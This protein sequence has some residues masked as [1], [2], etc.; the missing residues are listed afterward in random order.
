M[1]ST[2][3]SRR[4]MMT[5][6]ILLG[7]GASGLGSAQAQTAAG[8][9]PYKP[10]PMPAQVPA[11][12]GLA[13]LADTRL[14]YWDTG[15]DGQPIVL[16]HP[17]SG[18][19]LIWGYQQPVFVKAGYRVIAYSRRGHNGSDPVPKENPGIASGDLDHL[20]DFLGV[21]KF[22]AVSSAAG[23][24]VTM[25]Y[26]LSHADRL[27]S[28]VYACGTGGVQDE[29][30]VKM[31]DDL[32][33]KGF[34]EMPF[35]FQEVGP[36]YR[37]ANPEG[38]QQW[39]DLHHKAVT[40]V[41]TG[42]K[43]ANKVTLKA[44]EFDEGADAGDRRRRRPVVAADGLADGRAA[45][46]EQRDADRAGGRP[47]GLLGAARDVQPR[48]ARFHRKARDVR[49]RVFCK[50][51]CWPR[52][53]A[54]TPAPRS[55]DINYGLLVP[56]VINTCVIQ[57]VYA[58]VR[59]TTSYRA[60]E[61]NLSV[62]W[63]GVISATFAILPIFVAVRVGRFIDRGNDARAAWI[64]SGL[65]VAACA[66]FLFWS[67]SVTGLLLFTA[68][69]GVSHVYM[70]ASQQMLCIRSA[71]PRGR[72]AA[73][74]NYL[75]AAAIGQGLGP[76]V[77]AWAG[78][79]ATVPPTDKLFTIGLIIACVSMVTAGLLRPG[80]QAGRRHETTPRRSASHAAAPARPHGD[81][82]RERDHHH[83]AG[84]D[85][86]LPAADGHRAQHERERH[87]HLADDAVGGVTG[88][89]HGICDAWS[90]SSAACR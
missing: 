28:I 5:G 27:Y 3:L 61:L 37:A 25:D 7:A 12:E 56:L 22:H 36:S 24:S 55:N 33:P 20:M 58:L 23:V 62:V 18:S 43:P 85:H 44:L 2:V 42:Q 74:G 78:G 35:E 26:A 54:S 67:N 19:A 81:A 40:G 10:V 63:L 11:K 45:H 50:S 46:P 4:T 72:D 83:G 47:F 76:Y 75:V 34:A 48:S 79:A 29:H 41:R 57:M 31:L 84:F 14:F 60:I 13:Q 68:L 89:A 16:M 73:F 70:M 6:S 8:A 30:Y 87:R 49:C 1:T 80:A 65:L 52:A 17:A 69:L 32:R 15:G 59:V 9:D 39:A 88:V 38:T 66:G 71:G 64:G 86:D 51:F 53:R 82:H 77:I 21:K 90:G